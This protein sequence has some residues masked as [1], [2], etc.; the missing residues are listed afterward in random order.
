[1][2]IVN[3]TCQLREMNWDTRVYKQQ[4]EMPIVKV[5]KATYH[6]RL[7]AISVFQ[8]NGSICKYLLF[9]SEDDF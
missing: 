2:I 6:R 1:M 3:G 4:M 9:P 5:S 7:Q 8:L